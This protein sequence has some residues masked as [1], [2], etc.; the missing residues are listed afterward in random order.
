MIRLSLPHPATLLSNHR[1]PL[2][3]SSIHE[4]SQKWLLSEEQDAPIL[5]NSFGSYSMRLRKDS[6]PLVIVTLRFSTVCGMYFSLPKSHISSA[7]RTKREMMDK[8]LRIGRWGQLQGQLY[9][10]LSY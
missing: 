2:V 7:V 4:T 1:L 5:S 8:G 3:C 9:L 10:L 6:L